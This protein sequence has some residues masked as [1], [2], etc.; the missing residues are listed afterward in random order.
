[1]IRWVRHLILRRQ[2]HQLGTVLRRLENP[3]RAL[4]WPAWRR[5]QFWHDFAY[6]PRGREAVIAILKG[7]K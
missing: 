1:M 3:Q 5:K 2:I 4:K 6:G 7:M